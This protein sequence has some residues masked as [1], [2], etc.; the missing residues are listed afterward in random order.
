MSFEENGGKTLVVVRDL[1][2]SKEALDAGIGSTDGM[3]ETFDQLDVLPPMQRDPFARLRDHL[4]AL[5]DADDAALRAHARPQQR[6]AQAGA[7]T[8][9][10]HHVADLAGRDATR[11]VAE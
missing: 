11:A 6:Q 5:F 10:E 3:G 9:V 4:G 8:H 2:P 7:T 1:Y